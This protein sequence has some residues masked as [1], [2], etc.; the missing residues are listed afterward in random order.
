M[1]E[2]TVLGAGGWGTALA[3][4]VGRLGTP[5]RLWGRN[6][7]LVAT[8]RDE[9]RNQ[10][11]LA[12]VMFPPALTPTT[13]LED[14]LATADCVVSAVPSHGTRE[15][16]RRAAPLMRPDVTIISATKGFEGGTLH[17]M[18][19][20]IQQEAGPSRSTAVLSGPVSRRSWREGRPPRCS[21][22]ARRLM[23]PFGSKRTSGRPI[24]GSTRATMSSGLRWAAP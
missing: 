11:Y 17:R 6:A 4:H 22:P 15:V 3:I 13:S 19:E 12:D 5:V 21:S 2:V 1:R 7:A 14:A 20:V 18:S 16:M 9:R 23:S 10:A 8:L 24:S